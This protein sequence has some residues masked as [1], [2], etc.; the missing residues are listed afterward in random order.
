[1]A[2]ESFHRTKMKWK[3]GEKSL[4]PTYLQKIL[5]LHICLHYF[6]PAGLKPAGS[7][8]W[9]RTNSPL[10][11]R[12]KDQP[13]RAPWRLSLMSQTTLSL[14]IFLL[15]ATLPRFSKLFPFILP[16]FLSLC[17]L[18]PLLGFSFSLL[19]LLNLHFKCSPF[20]KSSFPSPTPYCLL[21][22]WSSKPCPCTT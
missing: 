10:T 13:L 5:A 19:S 6:F 22:I 15:S 17:I 14:N 16:T 7:A 18:L 9:L 20:F 2:R 21:F 3:K 4:A 8:T 11:R 1:M 12:A